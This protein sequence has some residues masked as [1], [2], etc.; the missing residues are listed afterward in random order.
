MQQR[1]V[2]VRVA[3]GRLCFASFAD[4]NGA[5]A[6]TVVTRVTAT[7]V[8]AALLLDYLCRTVQAAFGRRQG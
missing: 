1:S 3:T 8:A 6:G 5:F 2:A 4:A 7:V